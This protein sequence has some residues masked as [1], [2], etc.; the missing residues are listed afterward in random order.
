MVVTFNT[1]VLNGLCSEDQ[2]E[3]LDAVD[4]LRL[5]GI[6]HYI[7][8][9][10]IIVCGDQSS[11]KSSVLEA[12][13][14][15]PFPVKSNLCTRFPTELI[16]RRS[17]STDVTVSII[18]HTS[19]TGEKKKTLSA[20]HEKLDGFEGVPELIESAKVAMGISMQGKGF[21]K[22]LLRIEISGPHYPHLTIVD[23]PGLIHS[24]TRQQSASDVELVKDVVQT[25]M[26]QPR[27]IILAVI[28]AKNDFAN[29]IV[30]K[31]AQTID[32]SGKRTM[33]VITKPDTLVE[34]SGSEAM[35]V[36]LAQ[37][38]EIEFSLGWHVL[39]NLDSEKIEGSSL[40]HRRNEEEAVF[41]SKGVWSRLSSSRVGVK[42][43]RARLSYVLLQQ[44]ATELPSL[45]MEIDDK[46]EDC[47]DLLNELGEPR[48]TVH[49]QRLFL[50]RISQNFEH[51]IRDVKNG[52]YT[53][54]FFKEAD[55]KRGYEQRLRAIIQNLN[56]QFAIEML[57]NGHAR[58][59]ISPE[60]EASSRT[61]TRDKF[62]E[63]TRELMRRT[64]GCELPGRFNSSIVT[65]LFLKQSKPWKDI[66]LNHVEDCW[67]ATKR[68]LKLAIDHFAD[69]PTGTNVFRKVI[70]P[71]LDNLKKDIMLKA[72]ELIAS[73]VVCHP[74]TYNE[75]YLEQIH[76][77]NDQRR[78]EHY[79]QIVR[80][81]LGNFSEDS[82]RAIYKA[83]V[84]SLIE[85]LSLRRE[86]DAEQRAASEAADCMEAYYNV[87][88]KRI[89]DD[90]AIEVIER[91]LMAVL[92]EIF[93]PVVVLE[94]PDDLVSAIAGESQ[95]TRDERTKLANQVKILNKGSETCKRFAGP[96]LA[97]LIL[98][99]RGD[100]GD[101]EDNLSATL[102]DSEVSIPEQQSGGWR[103]REAARVA[104][105]AR[106]AECSDEEYVISKKSKKQK[107][108][109]KKKARHAASTEAVAAPEVQVM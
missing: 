62:I 101:T 45:I 37:N 39:R 36:S 105:R 16:L 82:Y 4:Q 26:K 67:D 5:Q 61:V 54:P 52:T 23:L 42:E 93:S 1:D 84:D 10:Q 83:N 18:P 109:E 95:D 38:K 47:T 64:R 53:D 11:G 35:F 71:A 91:K 44:V 99:L 8:L 3:L 90:V 66:V 40:L 79:T 25:Y 60:E 28:S 63:E 9:P 78:R 24:E 27:S 86:P 43:L 48:T 12:I 100:E 103:A 104:E 58:R 96:R 33:G 57:Q 85:K 81:T 98:P 77:I 46:L 14:G 15:V 76:R 21:S 69:G 51:L 30:L 72:R 50:A 68:C 17:P 107:K 80:T 2:L 89:I 88:L 29:Q 74:V 49:E 20:F 7:S 97:G 106:E 41:F 70:V 34:G 13:S 75:Q 108:K 92:S 55:T 65:D 56:G 87:A 32:P 102:D 73:Q 94:M 59:I 6:D 19:L 31:L 22:D